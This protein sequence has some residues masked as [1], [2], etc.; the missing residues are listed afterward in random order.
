MQAFDTEVDYTKANVQNI[1]EHFTQFQQNAEQGNTDAV[2]LI[3]DIKEATKKAKLTDQQKKV[4]FYR[5]L[6]EYTQDEV[7]EIMDI[8]QQA[9]SKH[10]E[11]IVLKIY[12]ELNGGDQQ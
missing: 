7:A 10:V 5:F 6:R 4:Y 2:V 8:S 9:I 3:V 12:R 11:L 1:L